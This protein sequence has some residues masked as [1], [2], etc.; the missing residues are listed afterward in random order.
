MC[1]AIPMK[2]EERT[3]FD[4]LVEWRGVSR[5][6]GMHLCP[7]AEV[8]DF[9]LVHAGYAIGKVDEEEAAKTLSLIEEVMDQGG[10]S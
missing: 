1:L 8:G 3:E 7:E 4:A 5:R 9:V 6:V 2:V 10:L